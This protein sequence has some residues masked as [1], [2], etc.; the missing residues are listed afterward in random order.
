MLEQKD[1]I[2]YVLAG[3]ITLSVAYA[4]FQ[5]GQSVNDAYSARTFTV[6]GTAKIQTANDIATFSATVTTE[7]G[8]DQGVVQNENSEAMN[9]VVGYLQT[10]G[11]AKEDIE[12]ENYNLSPRYN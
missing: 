10:N 7:G 9:K 11:I 5:Y 2:K 1:Q 4:A 6:E 12:T 3:I 8:M